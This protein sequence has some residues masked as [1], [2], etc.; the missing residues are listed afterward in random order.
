MT[1][2]SK[3]KAMIATNR[4][5]NFFDTLSIPMAFIRRRPDGSIPDR[6]TILQHLSATFKFPFREADIEWPSAE[7]FD[8]AG[9]DILIHLNGRLDGSV[10]VYFCPSTYSELPEIFNEY[11]RKAVADENVDIS[12]PT[13]RATAE[14]NRALRLGF[15][16]HWGAR[17]ESPQAVHYQIHF[18]DTQ[19]PADFEGWTVRLLSRNVRTGKILMHQLNLPVSEK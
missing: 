6:K 16:F 1:S 12:K 2:L 7:E 19:F 13:S 8:E 4:C 5:H 10:R 18:L 15:G 3:D 9:D 14:L 17:Y 11:L